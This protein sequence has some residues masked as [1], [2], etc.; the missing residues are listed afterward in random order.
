MMLDVDIES[1]SVIDKHELLS[2]I[3]QQ[4]HERNN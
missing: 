4:L 3:D 2:F 1:E